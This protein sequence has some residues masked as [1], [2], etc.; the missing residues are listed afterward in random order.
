MEARLTA[1]DQRVES[2]APESQEEALDD[3]TAKVTT[4]AQ[5]VLSASQ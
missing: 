1:L 5:G 2:V 4:S 3:L